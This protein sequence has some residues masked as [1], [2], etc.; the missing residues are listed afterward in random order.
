MDLLELIHAVE[1]SKEFAS[2]SK[3]YYLVHI[4]TI[5]D[6]HK[7]EKWDL[8]YYSKKTDKIIVFEFHD[9]SIKVNPPQEVF[10]EDGFVEKLVVNKKI[11]SKDAVIKVVESLMVEKYNNEPLVNIIMLLQNIKDHGQIWNITL[12]TLSFHVINIKINSTTGQVIKH[13]RESL[14]GWN[15]K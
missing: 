13:S 9:N 10:K 3:D 14:I 8:G 12:T 2:L 6:A 7:I 5:L 11:L 1:N 15:K 4:F